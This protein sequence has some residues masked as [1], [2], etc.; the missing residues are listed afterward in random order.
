[1][2]LKAALTAPKPA[3]RPA[4]GWRPTLRNAVAASG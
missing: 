3:A 1:L 4:S 2:T